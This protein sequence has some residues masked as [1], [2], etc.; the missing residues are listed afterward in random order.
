MADQN[1]LR[2]DIAVNEVIL[3]QVVHCRCQLRKPDPFLLFLYLFEPDSRDELKE[4]TLLAV[5][6]DQIV[7][8]PLLEGPV[9]LTAVWV[10]H[11]LHN[12]C[13]DFA[14]V[15]VHCLLQ[16]DRLP[17]R[18]ENCKIAGAERTLSQ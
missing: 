8:F 18:D 7:G 13:L 14:C 3:V 10:E 5:L 12:V 17:G 4:V 15:L 2:L 11:G 1:V 6:H 16:N 9:Q